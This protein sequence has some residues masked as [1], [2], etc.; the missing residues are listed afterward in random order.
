MNINEL[1]TDTIELMQEMWSRAEKAERERDEA[2]KALSD[3]AR[4]RGEAEGRL[5]ASEMAGVVDG[6]KARAEAAEA[7]VA[8]AKQALKIIAGKSQCIDNLMG[9]GDVAE[10]ALAAMEATDE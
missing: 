8:L 4:N 2:I 3:E 10:A 9:N 7:K 1:I 6:W 5:E